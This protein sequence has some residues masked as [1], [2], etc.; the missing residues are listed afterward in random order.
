MANRYMKRCSTSLIIQQVQIKITIRY[1]FTLSRMAITERLKVISIIMDVE[2]SK[3]FST[4]GG[5]VN[6]FS[7]YGK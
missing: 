4:V 1:H 7:H 6:C 5:S 3:P 2:K